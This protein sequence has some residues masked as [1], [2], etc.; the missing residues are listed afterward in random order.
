MIMKKFLLMSALCTLA[1]VGCKDDSEPEIPTDTDYS[2]LV[3]NEICGNDGNASEED[4]VEIYNTSNTTI[5]LNGVKLV[6]T[7]EEGI[8]E[9]IY[10]FAEGA[11]IAGKA[12]LLKVKGVDFTQGI[13]NTKSVAITLQMP[14]GK[15]I[16]KF[17][18]DK[19]L[20]ENSSHAVGGSYSRVPDGT[21]EWT[22]VTKATKG[23]ANKVTEPE[24]PSG[25]DYTGLVLN[26]LNGN[27]PTKYIELYNGADHELDITGV[28]I[29]K[30]DEEIVY[31]APENTKIASHGFLVLLS[32]QTDYSTGFTSGLSAKKSVMIELLSPENTAI[33]VFKNLT[34]AG[35]EIWGETPKYNGETEGM[36]YARKD[37]GAQ[38]Y[39]MKATQGESNSTTAGLGTKIEW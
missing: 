20:G 5:N 39:M 9:V 38:W 21:G 29:K 36:A 19:E 37:N 12:Y 1:L 18:R 16:D 14:S 30:D 34:D 25:I 23:G 7:D 33:D 24:E 17:D 2:G 3:L 6:K 27:K 8:S 31:I 15:D 26:E 32:D 22:V 11:T 13:S 35:E 4:W 28:Q 10:T